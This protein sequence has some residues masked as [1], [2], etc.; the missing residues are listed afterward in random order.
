[1]RAL[2]LMPIPYYDDV[3]Y[4]LSLIISIW[5]FRVQLYCKGPNGTVCR[6]NVGFVFSSL[7]EAIAAA[8]TVAAANIFHWGYA[9]DY[10]VLDSSGVVWIDAKLN[11]GNSAPASYGRFAAPN[12]ADSGEWQAGVHNSQP[13]V[14]R[15][16]RR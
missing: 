6:H 15:L 4:H 2:C 9:T 11:R 8:E 3:Y 1:M 10:R 16:N 12:S 14:R 7:K 5:M 13:S